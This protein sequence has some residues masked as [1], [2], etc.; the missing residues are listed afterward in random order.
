MAVSTQGGWSGQ[1]DLNLRPSAPK[2]DALPDCA[3]PRCGFTCPV[4]RRSGL[5][6][7]VFHAGENAD[8]CGRNY[9]S[10]NCQI[11]NGKLNPAF[12]ASDFGMHVGF[13]SDAIPQSFVQC[14]RLGASLFLADP[15]ASEAVHEDELVEKNLFGH[16]SR[17][18][19]AQA[20]L[21]N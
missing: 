9:P 11:A 16:A 5:T 15:G 18:I 3:I 20:P 8:R 2:A 17:H 7:E 1:Q 6:P 21:D 12:E 19:A 10:A 14:L 13:S 4:L